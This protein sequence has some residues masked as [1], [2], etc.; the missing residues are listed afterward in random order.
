M[1]NQV[2]WRLKISDALNGTSTVA[3]VVLL[4]IPH[5]PFFVNP[6]LA[7]ATRATYVLVEIY[8]QYG[9]VSCYSTVLLTDSC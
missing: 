6:T 2:L 1:F 3:V 9:R 4:Y 7:K 5:A 8:F